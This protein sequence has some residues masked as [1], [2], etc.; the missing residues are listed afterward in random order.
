[1]NEQADEMEWS[2]PSKARVC[3]CR[4]QERRKVSLLCGLPKSKLILVSSVS[5]TVQRLFDSVIGANT[6]P[7]AFTYIHGIIVLG[8]T[9]QEQL[10]SL[11]KVLRRLRAVNF[12]LNP[13][14]VKVGNPLSISDISLLKV[15]LKSTLRKLS[16][17]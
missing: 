7:K 9:S 10:D 17:S 13:D 16:P 1:M 11:W 15:E 5:S 2:S 6:E 8:R 4:S 14:K 12:I 3:R